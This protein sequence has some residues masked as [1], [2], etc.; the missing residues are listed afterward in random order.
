MFLRKVAL[1]AAVAAV[2]IGAAGGRRPS[3]ASGPGL[4]LGPNA[5]TREII[6]NLSTWMQ[7]AATDTFRARTLARSGLTI[8]PSSALQLVSDSALC[9]RAYN[10]LVRTDTLSTI[11]SNGVY[12]ITTGERYVVTDTLPAGEYSGLHWVFDT[13]F[14][15]RGTYFH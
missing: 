10:A 12:V 8:V 7:K 14:V 13:A 9:R 3:T 1:A 5:T 15:Y 6:S 11:P 2:G 4:C